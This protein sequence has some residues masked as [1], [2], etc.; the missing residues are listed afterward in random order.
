MKLQLKPTLTAFLLAAALP[1]SACAP[2]QNPPATPQVTLT[3]ALLT[4]TPDAP[5][6]EG[7]AMQADPSYEDFFASDPFSQ[8]STNMKQVWDP[9]HELYNALFYAT[10]QHADSFDASGYHLTDRQI[11]STCESLYEQAGLQLYYLY[12][13]K[14]DSNRQLVIFQYTEDTP[15]QI[16]ATQD[17]FY[18]QMN[19][20]LYNVAP[21]GYT[22]I[23]RFFS[24]YDSIARYADYT[25]DMNDPMKSTVNGI[26]VRHT[27]IC[28]SFSMLFSYALNFLGIPAE[29]VSNEAHAWNIVTLDGSRFQTDLTWGAG[30]AGGPESTIRY[31]LMDDARRIETLAQNGVAQYAI[32]SGYPRE[33]PA[34]PLPC[35]DA[36]YSPLTQ[37]YGTYA[38]DIENGWLYYT[39]DAGIQRMR[40]NGTQIE[41]VSPQKSNSIACFDGLL[42]FADGASAKL[43]RKLPDKTPELLDGSAPAYQLGLSDGILHYGDGMRM[44]KTIDLSPFQSGSVPEGNMR[45][46]PPAVIAD[47]HT[48]EIEVTFSKPMDTALLTRDKIGLLTDDGQSLPLYLQWSGDGKTLTIRSKSSLALENDVTLYIAPGLRS[49]N[50]QFTLSGAMKR[51]E[52]EHAGSQ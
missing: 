29:Y 45:H 41:N 15:E 2:L 16:Q 27:G 11:M 32:I 46:E 1:F 44:Q 9:D 50:A 3:P 28:G 47:T 25:D 4:P 20:L 17:A 6:I 30:W 35:T 48:Y 5:E 21:E 31:A 38:L 39:D 49:I 10:Q 33:N 22:P 43:Y 23:Q 51:I 37:A 36:R 18:K 24:V 13:V 12:R 26:L 40:L 52:R 14:Y 42:Y 19:H 34:A 7:V 8:L